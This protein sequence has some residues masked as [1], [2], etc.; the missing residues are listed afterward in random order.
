MAPVAEA[1]KEDSWFN[2]KSKVMLNNSKKL[3]TLK[4]T[5]LNKRQIAPA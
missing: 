1:E 5:N 2:Y 4:L 3:P